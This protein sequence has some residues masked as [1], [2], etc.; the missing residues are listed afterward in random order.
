MKI[1]QKDETN[2]NT[3]PTYLLDGSNYLN[4]EHSPPVIYLTQVQN[5][6]NIS[7]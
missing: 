6:E 7:S 4:M 2:L 5:R 1:A 3:L